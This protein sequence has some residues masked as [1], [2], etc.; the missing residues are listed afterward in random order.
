MAFLS[1]GVT[2][3][4]ILKFLQF[5]FLKNI[6]KLEPSFMCYMKN[7]FLKISSGLY[8]FYVYSLLNGWAKKISLRFPSYSILL[9]TGRHKN[10]SGDR[11][12]L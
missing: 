3:Q 11:Y 2:V 6:H 4:V 5:N 10:I 9:L 8:Y 7:K 12:P 1:I